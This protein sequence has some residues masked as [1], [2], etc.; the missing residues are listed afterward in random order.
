MVETAKEKNST[1]TKRKQQAILR[2]RNKNY[3]IKLKCK[4][5]IEEK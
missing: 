3:P 5:T 4:S 1:A 2:K